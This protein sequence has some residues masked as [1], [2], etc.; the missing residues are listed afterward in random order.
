MTASAASVDRASADGKGRYAAVNGIELYY[1]VHGAGE[2]LVLLAGGFG[3]VEMFAS[4]LP[5]LAETRRVIG[6]ELQGH[7]HTPDVAD[8]PLRFE[9]MADDV[10]ALI[11]HLGL[12]WAD[13]LGYSLG[14][15]VALQVSLRHPE[16]VR[17]LVLVSAPCKRDGWYA[18]DLAGMAAVTG[19][20]AKGWVGSPM[21][22]AYASVA[23]RP[24]DWP[25][26]ADKLSALLRQDYD[27][28]AAVA[29]MRVPTLIVIGDA[30]GVRPGHA[31]ELLGLLGGAKAHGIMDPLPAS[32]LAILPGTSHYNIVM[33]GE[34][35]LPMV[36]PFLAGAVSSAGLFPSEG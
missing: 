6:V 13:V 24:E 26:L 11:A 5:A 2:P 14:G 33:P 15:G 34:L 18:E 32:R 1:E 30:D 36:M 4:I 12:G 7:G 9:T 21:H 16:A 23:P 29:E 25:L 19:E 35:L 28:S 20:A 3:G 27:W 17:R 10:A 8:R 22:T 31:V